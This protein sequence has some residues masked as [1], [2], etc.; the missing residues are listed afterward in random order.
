M[1]QLHQPVTLEV[2]SYQ[3]TDKRVGSAFYEGH[4]PNTVKT[5][6]V[7]KPITFAAG[8]YVY[9]M[10]QPNGNLIA[11][12]LEPEAPSSFVTFGIIPVDRK[13]A[14]GAASEAPVYRLMQPLALDAR[15]GARE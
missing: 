6:V 9:A 14:G 11:A 7:R 4:I 1:R 13:D 15:L 3:V 8:S 12:A 2:E 10:A 5:E